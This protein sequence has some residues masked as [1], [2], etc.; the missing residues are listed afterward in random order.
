MYVSGAYWIAKKEFMI[1]YPLDE[2]FCWGQGEDGVW[3]RSMRK[4]WNYK[5]NTHS[6]VRLLKEK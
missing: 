6:I 3:V 4:V 2:A 5:M 1:K